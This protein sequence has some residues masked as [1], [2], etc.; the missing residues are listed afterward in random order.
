[1][2]ST[3]QSAALPE[4]SDAWKQAYRDPQLIARRS[5]KHRQKLQRLGVLDWPRE[6]KLLDLC[7]GTGEVLRILHAE[8]FKDLHGLDVT[9]DEELKKESWLDA[10]AGDSRALPYPDATFDAVTCL[11]SLHHLGGVD[12][13]RAA[14]NEAKRI[15][16][17][18]GRL[19]LIDHFDSLQLRFVFS[20]CRQP[21]LTWPT[22]GLRSFRK[23]LD[24]EWTYL[25]EYLDN[26]AKV[27]GV[28]DDLGFA[29]VE[30]D[31]R[32]MFFFYWCGK[33]RV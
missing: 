21:W 2:S 13:I 25:T 23:Q 9:V 1:M 10:K 5:K 22:S 27:R 7:C 3:P 6:T 14:L 12:G 19:A 30:L 28:I 33:K 24:E 15:L 32:G 17:P 31:R 29:P 4:E 11:H 8:G 16:K 20:A 26:W 18:G